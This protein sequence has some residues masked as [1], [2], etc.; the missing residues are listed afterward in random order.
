MPK[1]RRA[2]ETLRPVLHLR[3]DEV[4]GEFARA[5]GALG[6]AAQADADRERLGRVHMHAVPCGV[7]ALRGG[8]LRRPP[9]GE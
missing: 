3:D 9:R 1:R 7:Q 8:A 6:Y 2:F 5:A 4:D